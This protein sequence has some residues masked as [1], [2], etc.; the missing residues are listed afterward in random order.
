MLFRS[1][2]LPATHCLSIQL[3]RL[4]GRGD[5]KLKVSPSLPLL[6]AHSP[7]NDRQFDQFQGPLL[8]ACHAYKEFGLC[9][10]N[11]ISVYSHVQDIEHAEKFSDLGQL[12]RCLLP[13]G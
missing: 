10:I 11:G 7:Y 8:R 9:R 1:K 2:T 6:A 3:I 4:P 13:R 12:V 5:G